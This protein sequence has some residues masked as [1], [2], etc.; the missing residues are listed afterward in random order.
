MPPE[1]AAPF[2]QPNVSAFPGAEGA[3]KWAYG[4]RTG[5]VFEVTSLEDS[6][7]GTLREAVEAEGPRTVVFRTGG[8]IHLEDRLT[9]THPYI[10]IAGQ[11]APGGGIV[12]ADRPFWINPYNVI[13][14]HIRVRYGDSFE[15]SPAIIVDDA[16]GG[17]PVSDIIVDH[18]SASWGRDENL[19]FYKMEDSNNDGYAPRPSA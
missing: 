4:G 10:T 15:E 1:T 2:V 11:T 12:I 8:V 9:I 16:F 5:R 18:V 13:V 19:S 6:G 3:G 17:R 14:R 7:P